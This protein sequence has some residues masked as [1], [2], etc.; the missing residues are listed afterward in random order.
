[1]TVLSQITKKLAFGAALFS[2]NFG[3]FNAAFQ[4]PESSQA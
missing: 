3:F 4:V 2:V 1:V